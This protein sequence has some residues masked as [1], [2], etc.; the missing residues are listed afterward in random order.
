MG[1]AD[2]VFKRVL[3]ELWPVFKAAGFRRAS[4]N[5]AVQSDECWAVINFQK[6]RWS[7]ADE[8]TFYIN[9]AI[10]PKRLMAFHDQPTEKPPIYYTCISVWRA[11]QL[12]PPESPSQWTVRDEGSEKQTVDQ[13]RILIRD[14]VI[15]AVQAKM[16]EDA[17][18][19]SWG[20]VP[21]DYRQL[22]AK[23]V[24]A[25][26]DGAVVELRQ[27]IFELYERFGRGGTDEGVRLHHEQLRSKFLDTMIRVEAGDE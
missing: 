4:Q 14:W 23:S 17:L 10:T 5:F 8:K 16:S 15:P 24:L 9:V 6:S 7:A 18:I 2:H 25:A 21:C 13:L 20:L 12:G 22:K 1:D 11:E 26:A 27:L 19:A 3:S